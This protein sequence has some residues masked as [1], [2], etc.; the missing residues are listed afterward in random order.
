[1]TRYAVGFTSQTLLPGTY[2]VKEEK[3]AS[4]YI[5]T[6]SAESDDPWYPTRTVTVESDGSTAVVVFANVPNPTVEAVALKKNAEYKGAG[7]GLQSAVESE[8]QTI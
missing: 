8:Y 2:T 1:G 5:F 3:E 4:G 7:T 6:P